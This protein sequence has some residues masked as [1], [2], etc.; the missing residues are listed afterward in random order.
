MTQLV[1]WWEYGVSDT[2]L[3]GE[4]CVFLD[5]HVRQ[6]SSGELEDITDA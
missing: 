2:M 5:E 6:Q 3:M 4:Q 1:L